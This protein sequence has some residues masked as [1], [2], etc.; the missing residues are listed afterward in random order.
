M[1][2]SEHRISSITHKDQ[3]FTEVA[4]RPELGDLDF[5]NITSREG[6]GDQ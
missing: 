4:R 3:I 5:T 1:I 2:N 6:N